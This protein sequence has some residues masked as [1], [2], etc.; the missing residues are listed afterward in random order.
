LNFGWKEHIKEHIMEERNE[1]VTHGVLIILMGTICNF[2]VGVSL[3]GW[4]VDKFSFQLQFNALMYGLV[5]TILTIIFK[6][7]DSMIEILRSTAFGFVVGSGLGI[8]FEFSELLYPYL[9]IK[10]AGV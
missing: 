6:W 5:T 2:V 3:F 4:Q 10:K 9:R 7:P 1:I 8:G